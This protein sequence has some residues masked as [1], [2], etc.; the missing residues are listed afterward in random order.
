[1]KQNVST[2]PSSAP[3]WSRPL[4]CSAGIFMT[5]AVAGGSGAAAAEL[6]TERE[7]WS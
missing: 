2:F 5:V 3:N 6:L 1:M 4:R 7:I